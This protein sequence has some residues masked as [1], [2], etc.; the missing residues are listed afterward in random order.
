[1]LYRFAAASL[2]AVAACSSPQER[3]ISAATKDLRVVTG[4]VA[5]AE[6]NI[7]RGYAIGTKLT[8]TTERVPCLDAYGAETT[9]EVTVPVEEKTR[10]AIDLDTEA[11]KLASLKRKQA[12]LQTRAKGQIAQCK[13]AHPEG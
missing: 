8:T 9:C 2:L 11:A 4:F 3:C 7:A 5:E 1:M 10:A 6:A 13:A 12:E